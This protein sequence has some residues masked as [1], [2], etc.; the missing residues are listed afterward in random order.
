MIASAPSVANPAMTTFEDT[1][2]VPSTDTSMTGGQGS[3]RF[4]GR[5]A[6]PNRC[7]EG[8]I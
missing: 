8:K 2:V 1:L 6:S 3:V 7:L 4:L 5:P